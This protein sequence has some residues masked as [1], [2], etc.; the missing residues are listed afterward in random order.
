MCGDSKSFEK[1]VDDSKTYFSV[2]ETLTLW[3]LVACKRLFRPPLINPRRLPMSTGSTDRR[4]LV[5]V[6][7]IKV[8]GF[9]LLLTGVT[10]VIDPEN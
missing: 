3:K 7:L 1:G 8:R 5:K 10:M 9:F 6:L 2:E 4:V